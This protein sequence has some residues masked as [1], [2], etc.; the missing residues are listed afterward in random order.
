[1]LLSRPSDGTRFKSLKTHASPDDD[2]GTFAAIQGHMPIHCS[3]FEHRFVRNVPESFDLR[4]LSRP[5]Q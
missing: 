5:R 2:N 3:F 4:G 1:M